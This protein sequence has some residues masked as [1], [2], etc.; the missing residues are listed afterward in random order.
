M[1][2]YTSTLMSNP[3]TARQL[4][5]D[6]L[7]NKYP[8]LWGEIDI[9]SNAPIKFLRLVE[10]L[11]STSDLWM[12]GKIADEYL[13][14]NNGILYITYQNLASLLDTP[15]NRDMSLCRQL[16]ILERSIPSRF[17]N[18]YTWVQR[19]KM[20][21][22]TY[23]REA[24]V[25]KMASYNDHKLLWVK[26]TEA[27]PTNHDRLVHG[28]GVKGAD[29]YFWDETINSS[30]NRDHM[31]KV[32]M[33]HGTYPLSSMIS[34]YSDPT[35]LYDAKYVLLAMP[36]GKYYMINYNLTSPIAEEIPN[37]KIPDK[38]IL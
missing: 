21:C 22:N 31:I 17:G 30:N 14:K 5:E 32:E 12:R 18:Y 9:L 27:H 19:L 7:K 25:H 2:N 28:P 4:L 23:Y 24:A 36:D 29:F 35:Y 11:E 8:T 34:K 1:E 37:I 38:Y 6:K 26:G 3:D 33:K 10:E 16:Y 13:I 20:F 15:T